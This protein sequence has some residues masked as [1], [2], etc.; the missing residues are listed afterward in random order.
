[1]LATPIFTAMSQPGLGEVSALDQMAP[2]E[3]PRGLTLAIPELSQDGQGT[4]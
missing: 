1:M 4:T 2:W 3:A